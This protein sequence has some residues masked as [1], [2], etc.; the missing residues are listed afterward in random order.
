MEAVASQYGIDYKAILKHLGPHPGAD[1][2][3]D[4]IKPCCMFD[5]NDPEQIK[6][7]WSPSNLQWLPASV[8]LSKGGK[9]VDDSRRAENSDSRSDVKYSSDCY[10]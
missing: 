7:C 4:H 10:Q 2:H 5:H 3:L 8:N 1:Y 9:Y 6:E